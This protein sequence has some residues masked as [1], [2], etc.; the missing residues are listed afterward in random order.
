M[1]H[2]QNVE[3]RQLDILRMRFLGSIEESGGII[4]MDDFMY[5]LRS[6][7]RGASKE[8]EQLFVDTIQGENNTINYHKLCEI[9]S[10]Y[11]YHF[12]TAKYLFRS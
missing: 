10:V 5:L 11:Q 1:I 3:Y 8:F 9:I 6:V 7:I 2:E 12:Y 4:K